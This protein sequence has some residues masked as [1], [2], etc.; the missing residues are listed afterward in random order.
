VDDELDVD[1][2]L[3]AIL[4]AIAQLTKHLLHDFAVAERERLNRTGKIYNDDSDFKL[5]ELNFDGDRPLVTSAVVELFDAAHRYRDSVVATQEL[6][7]RAA[8]VR[9]GRQPD[10]KRQAT[11][12]R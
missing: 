9:P 3:D 10:R 11:W 5:P 1:E 8:A 4:K 12:R 6:S 2:K 7:K